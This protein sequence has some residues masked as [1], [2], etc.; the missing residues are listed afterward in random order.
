MHKAPWTNISIFKSGSRRLISQMSAKV[1]SRDKT[2]TFAPRSRQ[3]FAVS[4]DP[5]LACV[6]TCKGVRAACSRM[7]TNTPGSDTI[8][9]SG[10]K[11]FT[12]FANSSNRPTSAFL[13]N[14]FSVR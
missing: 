11:R 12:V 13:E 7:N 14:R 2:Q 1:V 6:E 4:H 9:P 8:S 10:R 5:T 3:N